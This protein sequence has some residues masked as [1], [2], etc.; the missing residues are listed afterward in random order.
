M[1]QFTAAKAPKT[2][3]Q[4]AAVVAYFYRF[5]APPDQRRETIGADTLVEAAR[6]A[7]RRRPA[8]AYFTLNN[9]KNAG[10]LDSAGTGQF[11]INSVGEN[12][13]AMALPGD[14]DDSAPRTP[15]K[16]ADK[17]KAKESGRGAKTKRKKRG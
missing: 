6:L 3:Q 13:V 16:K 15:R 7:G 14:D 11:Q 4:F 8:K 5:E 12:L 9:A 10:Y 1:K 2:D 17:K